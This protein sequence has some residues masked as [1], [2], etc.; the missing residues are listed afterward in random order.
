MLKI[1]LDVAKSATVTTLGR[2]ARS[3]RRFNWR[4]SNHYSPSFTLGG[5]GGGI[6]Y[7]R[8]E[9]EKMV[10]NGLDMSPTTE[11]LVEECL[12]GWKEYEMESCATTRI[13]A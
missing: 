10:Q 5:S 9:Y 3:C 12:L 13:S 4:L 7:N 2:C 8:E 1:G 11:V 6:A